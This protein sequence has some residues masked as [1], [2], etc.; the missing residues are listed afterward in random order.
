VRYR[1]HRVIKSARL[2]RQRRPV[3]VSELC[4]QG[5]VASASDGPVRR[6]SL[7]L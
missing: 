7:S 4:R 5:A 3:S 6:L 2:P 1:R